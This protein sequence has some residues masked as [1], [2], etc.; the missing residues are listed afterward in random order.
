MKIIGVNIT[1][2]FILNGV[3]VTTTIQSSSIWSG[4]V[5]SS[6]VSINSTTASLNT[7]TS[8]LNAY[9]ASA[10][11]RLSSIELTTGSLNTASGSAANYGGVSWYPDTGSAWFGRVGVLRTNPSTS[12]LTIGVGWS[13]SGIVTSLTWSGMTN[14]T[15][16]EI[17]GH[18]HV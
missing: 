7:T 12:H 14:S 1:G 4:S 10:S 16:W 15:E 11:N 5:A 8:S 3:D 17:S 18:Y 9:T 6:I 13:G 2:S